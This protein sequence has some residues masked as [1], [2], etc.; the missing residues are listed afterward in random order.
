MIVDQY[1]RSREARTGIFCMDSAFYE[2][3]LRGM[4]RE[5][6][7]DSGEWAERVLYRRLARAAPAG[8]RLFGVEPGRHGISGATG[9]EMWAVGPRQR[10]KTV[11]RGLNRLVDRRYL[12]FSG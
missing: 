12:W 11:A 4:Y 5:C 3:A 7:D 8:V 1:R 9:Q 2:A 6:N 10:L